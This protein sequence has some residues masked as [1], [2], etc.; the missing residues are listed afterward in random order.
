MIA[1]GLEIVYSTRRRLDRHAR[2]RAVRPIEY[3]VEIVGVICDPRVGEPV[4]RLF[5]RRVELARAVTEG[6]CA[7]PDVFDAE[8]TLFDCYRGLY[9][10]ETCLP[11]EAPPGVPAA[12][13]DLLVIDLV[14]IDPAR[15]GRGLGLAALLE[16]IEVWGGGCDFAC[17]DSSPIPS[18]EAPPEGPAVVRLD[19]DGPWV[20]RKLQSYWAR[21]GF[22]PLAGT[23]CS[24]L[25]LRPVRTGLPGPTA[26]R[27]AR[28]SGPR[29]A[30]VPFVLRKE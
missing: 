22:V 13:N 4:G 29:G 26:A 21:L 10:V 18:G 6:R 24:A 28:E 25:D 3:V 1:T 20:V 14:E 23:S 15:R 27:L 11:R 9:D 8:Q 16:T 12:H 19:D 7:L 5:A 17:V 2:R 30:V